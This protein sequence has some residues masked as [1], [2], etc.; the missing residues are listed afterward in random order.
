MEIANWTMP[1]KRI[2]IMAVV[3]T[4]LILTVL[5]TIIIYIYYKWKKQFLAH[6]DDWFKAAMGQVV[7]LKYKK[8]EKNWLN[9]EIGR[10]YGPRGR[11]EW[12]R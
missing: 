11:N 8:R 5:K 10:V 6:D 2:L 7:F 12:R 1:Q 3:S 4:Y 9:N